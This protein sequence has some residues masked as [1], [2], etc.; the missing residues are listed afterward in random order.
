MCK[1]KADRPGRLKVGGIKGKPGLLKGL[2]REGKVNG[3]VV[4]EGIDNGV[5]IGGSTGG[6]WSFFKKFIG[7]IGVGL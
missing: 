5:E 1:G 4:E 3:V 2:Y 7:M 6:V